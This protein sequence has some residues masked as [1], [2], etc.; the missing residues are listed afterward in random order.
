MVSR[1]ERSPEKAKV[2]L[3]QV[4]ER[5]RRRGS[6]ACLRPDRFR[7][8]GHHHTVFVLS[9]CYCL[10]LLRFLRATRK[11]W[12]AVHTL[13]HASCA[14]EPLTSPRTATARV[15]GPSLE[16][17]SVRALPVLRPPPRSRLPGPGQ[18]NRSSPH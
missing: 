7:S 16:T 2:R 6:P 4:L 13:S 12:W 1:D 5:D 3:V 11:T 8:R 18:S 10:F 9:H 15:R 17:T 14:Q